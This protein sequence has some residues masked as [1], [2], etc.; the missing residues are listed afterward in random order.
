M[1]LAAGL[2]EAK[3]QEPEPAFTVYGRGPEDQ[4]PGDVLSA[5]ARDTLLAPAIPSGVVCRPLPPIHISKCTFIISLRRLCL[6]K[7]F[8]SPK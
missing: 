8:A 4:P 5:E 3:P 1:E 2:W 6:L 7:D